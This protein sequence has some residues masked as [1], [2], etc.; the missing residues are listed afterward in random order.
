[1]PPDGNAIHREWIRYYDVAPTELDLVVASWDT[2]STLGEASDYSAGT[3]WGLKGTD[4][5]L[6]DVIRERLEVPDLR[7]RIEQV[8]QRHKVDATLIEET[9]IGRALMQEM[10]RNSPVRPIG[11]RPRFDKEARLLAQ[12]PKFEAGQVLLPRE[13]PWLADYV[14]ELLAFPN[15]AHDDQVDSTSQALNWLSE[16]MARGIPPRRPDP[17]RP[18]GGGR[19]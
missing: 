17:Q 15:G 11:R 9:D 5:Y 6:L 16:R 14:S 4:I 8:S 3:V 10:R 13:A 18:P 1:M 12:A 2:A 7:R 19:G